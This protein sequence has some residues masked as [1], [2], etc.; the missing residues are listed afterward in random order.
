M[1][2]SS[3]RSTSPFKRLQFNQRHL[4]HPSIRSRPRSFKESCL[5]DPLHSKIVV[6]KA[7]CFALPTHAERVI[8][9][10]IAMALFLIPST[11]PIAAQQNLT[12]SLVL[13]RKALSVSNLGRL[14][15]KLAVQC[16]VA[17]MS[18]L[19]RFLNSAMPHPSTSISAE[20]NPQTVVQPLN[21]HH[22]S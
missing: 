5:T 10:R 2:K 6:R 22:R 13:L 3:A 19:L 4:K 17:I 7:S 1:L 9:L 8:G 14:S 16:S 15:T 12:S 11:K 21:L 20:S 18:S